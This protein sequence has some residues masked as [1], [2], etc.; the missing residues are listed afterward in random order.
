GGQL[1]DFLPG[2]GGP[3]T[4]FP[5]LESAFVQALSH[6]LQQGGDSGLQLI[7]AYENLLPGIP[8]DQNALVVL[9]VLGTKL[10][11]DGHTLHLPLAELPSG[12]VVAVVQLDPGKV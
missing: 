5:V 6:L 1:L 12:A 11:T 3:G 7:Q 8:A 4:G 10:Q 9:N 2:V